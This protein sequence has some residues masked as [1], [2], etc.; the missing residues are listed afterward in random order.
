ME[1]SSQ[2]ENDFCEIFPNE[3]SMEHEPLVEVSKE[4]LNLQIETSSILGRMQVNIEKK[5]HV[6][7]VF[8]RL[9]N[10]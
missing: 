9:L 1:H 10:I 4:N 6:Q 2:N 7:K 8:W 3:V 5:L